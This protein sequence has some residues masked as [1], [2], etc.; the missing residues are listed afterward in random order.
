VKLN[1]Y[2]QPHIKYHPRTLESQKAKLPEIR[3]DYLY[4]LT[5][6][7][8]I[9]QHATFSVPNRQHGYC[10]DDNARALIV[11]LIAQHLISH[12]PAL[13][14]LQYLYMSFLYHAYNEETGRFRNFMSYDRKWEEPKGSQ[15]AHGRALWALGINA[16]LT[17]DTGL[18]AL[19]TTLFKR[20]LTEVLRFTHPRALSFALIGIRAYLSRYSGDSEVR[21]VRREVCKRI[22][23]PFTEHATD[24]WPWFQHELSYAN[25]KVAHALLIAGTS[26]PDEAVLNQGFATIDWLM[27]LQTRGECFS[28]IGNNGW[29]TKN[30]TRAHFDQQ[31][32]EAHAMIEACLE[33]WRISGKRIYEDYAGICM[34]WFLG[35]N[36]LETPLYDFST[37]GCCDGLLP[38]GANYNQGAESTLAWLMSLI[39]TYIHTTDEQTLLPL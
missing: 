37:A 3:L 8:G 16:A 33:A 18:L 11:V 21:R 36:D 12:D 30:G 34:D 15:D 9:I 7:T 27:K 29:A 14:E 5:D 1:R 19:G 38:D 39:A 32:I 4:R 17:R 35:Q 22:Y 24:D 6:D 28:P 26:L 2:D 20:A 31:P 13:S 25:G 23:K 10:T